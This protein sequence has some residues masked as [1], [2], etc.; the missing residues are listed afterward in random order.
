MSTN[1]LIVRNEKISIVCFY[2]GHTVAMHGCQKTS[3]IFIITEIHHKILFMVGTLVLFRIVTIRE[4][5]S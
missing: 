3:K 2:Q 1:R 5:L 4:H